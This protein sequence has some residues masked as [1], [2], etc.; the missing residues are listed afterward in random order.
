MRAS[1]PDHDIY[2]YMCICSQHESSL[3]LAGFGNKQQF[4]SK[5]RELLKEKDD[6]CMLA[7]CL[8]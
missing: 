6:L 3:L 8:T 5:L 2:I 7:G 1:H 4:A